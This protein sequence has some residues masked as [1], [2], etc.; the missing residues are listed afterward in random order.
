MKRAL[1]I[2]LLV[3]IAVPLLYAMSELPPHGSAQSPPYRHVSAYYLR[4]GAEEAGAENIVTTV[5][6]NYRGFD[7]AGEVT[8]IFTSLAAVLAILVGVRRGEDPVAEEPGADVPV[9]D[10]VSFIVRLLAPAIALFAI[11]VILNGHVSPGGGFQGGAIL[12]A[13][14]IV[15]TMVV[16]RQQAQALVPRGIR[17]FLQIAAPLAFIAV[18]TAGLLAYGHFLQFPRTHDLEWVTLTG[19]TI[20]EIGI[21]VGGAAILASI[22]WA[23]RGEQ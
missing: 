14:L 18:G 9:S 4:N 2:V 23:M 16:G 6:L 10:V 12:A 15:I 5:I 17:K 7:T 19:L 8:V 21:G 20:I 3:L 1:T 13:L 11:Y 22:F